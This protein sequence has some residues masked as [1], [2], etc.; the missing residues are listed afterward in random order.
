MYNLSKPSNSGLLPIL[1]LILTSLLPAGVI[2]A[3]SAPERA[4]EKVTIAYSSLSGNM[5]PLWIT[6]ERGFFRKNG[7]DVQLVFI[8][9]GT[10]TVQSLIS[11][12]VYFAQMAGAAVIQSRLRGTDVVMIAG[13][14]NTL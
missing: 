2:A 5:A 4:L 10:T 8:E 6:H 13:V 12:D 7:L 14:I 11:K 3:E 1:V 9:S